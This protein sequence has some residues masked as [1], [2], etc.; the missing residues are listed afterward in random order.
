MNLPMLTFLWFLFLIAC[1]KKK[2]R[3]HIIKHI[4]ELKYMLLTKV[5]AEHWSRAKRVTGRVNSEEGGPKC[6]WADC[7]EPPQMRCCIFC[8]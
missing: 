1:K 5:L 2:K 3:F 4:T 8:V 7:L 6:E